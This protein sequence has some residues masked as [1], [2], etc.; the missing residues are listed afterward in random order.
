[1]AGDLTDPDELLAAIVR[2]TPG[3]VRV[4]R[5]AVLGYHKRT[6][7][8][9]TLA[10]FGPGGKPTPFEGLR[11]QV[12]DI[13]RLAHRLVSLKLPALLKESSKEGILPPF[14]QKRLGGSARLVV[15]PPGPR[16]FLR[17]PLLRDTPA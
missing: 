1:M 11:I 14:L 2:I 5:C 13:P 16:P 6:R 12:A 10:S 4:D 9:H 8:F 7:E 3:L 15:P 17:A